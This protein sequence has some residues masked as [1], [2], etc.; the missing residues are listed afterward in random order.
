MVVNGGPNLKG[1][2]DVM[3]K[4]NSVENEEDAVKLK[5]EMD[6]YLEKELGVDVSKL[7][8]TISKTNLEGDQDEQ[9]EQVEQLEQVENVEQVEQVQ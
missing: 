9:V 8:E 4:L 3:G 7:N 1:L 5:N 2:M 6:N